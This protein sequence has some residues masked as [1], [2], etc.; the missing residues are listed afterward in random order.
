MKKIDF[1][2]TSITVKKRIKMSDIESTG[3]KILEYNLV[4]TKWR[5]YKISSSGSIVVNVTKDFNSWDWDLSIKNNME[6]FTSDVNIKLQE[7]WRPL[8]AP[9]LSGIWISRRGDGDGESAIQAIVREKLP[10]R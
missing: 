1:F 7:G 8:G 6:K 4:S 9:I 2:L 3:T 5:F 10:S